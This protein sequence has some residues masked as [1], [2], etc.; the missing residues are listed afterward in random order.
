MKTEPNTAE[1][2]IPAWLH[3]FGRCMAWPNTEA[4]PNMAPWWQIIWNVAWGVPAMGFLFIYCALIAVRYMSIQ[5]GVSTWRM[6]S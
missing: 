4:R 3:H 2:G 5:E 6:A 1:S